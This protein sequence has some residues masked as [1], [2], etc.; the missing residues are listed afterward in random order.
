LFFPYTV[1]YPAVMI[2]AFLAPL[3]LDFHSLSIWQLWR[4]VPR[5]SRPVATLAHSGG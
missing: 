4:A 3:S 5:D 1:P 2:P